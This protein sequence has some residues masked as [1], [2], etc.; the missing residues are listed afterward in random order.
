MPVAVTAIVV[1]FAEP[2]STARALQ[3]LTDQSLTPLELVVVDND[4]QGRT[5]RALAEA[6]TSSEFRVLRP[7]A[8][9]GYTGAANL[10]ARHALGDWLF[11]LNPDAVAASDCLERLLE[12]VDGPEVAVAGAQILLPDGR[13]NAGDNPVNLAGI[14]WSGGFGGP[15]EHGIARDTAAVSGAALLVR[16]ET[17][18][19]I[20]GL[21]PSFFLYVDD[22]DLAWRMRLAGRRVRFCPE[23]VVVHDYEFDKGRQKWFFLERNRIWALLSNLQLRTLGLLFP[24]L[25]A[26]EAAVLARAAREGWLKEKAAAWVSLL[27]H[28]PQLIRWRRRVQSTRTLPDRDVLELFV[29]GIETE[30][31]N[32]RLLRWVNPSME[33]YRRMVMRA[34]QRQRT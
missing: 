31:I 8:N 29:G 34:L 10:A 30:L 7:G 9:L 32:T 21:C 25:L 17:F 23:A 16:R 33:L 6:P 26:T 14:S 27:W 20:G 22:T 3:S 4:P 2:S 28:A 18:L 12:A 24:L 13:I 1:S 15:R 19:E 5:A 11:F